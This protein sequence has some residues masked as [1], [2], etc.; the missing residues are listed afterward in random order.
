MA[1]HI[2]FFANTANAAGETINEPTNSSTTGAP[3]WSTDKSEYARMNVI[4]NVKTFTGTSP[5]VTFAILERFGG[6]FVET[7]RSTAITASGTYI[8]AQHAAPANQSSIKTAGAFPALGS[9][10]D[11]QVITTTAGTQVV[12][13]ADIYFDFFS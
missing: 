4:L 6:V 10:T 3:A 12:I 11:K 2:V 5:V 13:D 9:G 7:A 8:L 1:K